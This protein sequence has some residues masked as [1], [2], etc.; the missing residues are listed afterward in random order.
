MI[1]DK[2]FEVL[3][4]GIS[5]VIVAIPSIIGAVHGVLNRKEVKETKDLALAT[6][7]EVRGFANQM[8]GMLTKRVDDARSEGIDIGEGRSAQRYADDQSNARI[9]AAA[10]LFSDNPSPELVEK[11]RLYLYGE[12]EKKHETP[13]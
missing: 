8:D 12:D 9:A 13:S 6:K 11:I 2:V 3:I 1:S 5:T 4:T 10:G 7:S